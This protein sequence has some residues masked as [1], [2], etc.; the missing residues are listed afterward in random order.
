MKKILNENK[1][2][3]WLLYM[4]I[5]TLA[6]NLAEKSI[7]DNYWVS[8]LPLDDKI[9]FVRQ[10]VYPYVFWYIFMCGT[11]LYLLIKDPDGFR[12]YMI[13]I[14]IGYSCT[15]VFCFIFPNG[16]NLRVQQPG[17]DFAGSLI[18]SIYNRDTNTNVL[19]S[20]HVLGTLDVVFAVF[21]CKSL[22]N[23]ILRV[24]TVIIGISICASTVMIKQHS[25]LDVITALI[26]SG[27]IYLL[28]YVFMSRK[29]YP[30]FSK[31]KVIAFVEGLFFRD[32]TVE[33]APVL[34]KPAPGRQGG[35]D[36]AGRAF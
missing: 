7:V 17:E 18:Q 11:G 24:C 5:Y 27:I 12:R 2:C 30:D 3:I 35:A 10:M 15:L 21:Y 23:P 16:Q 32:K 6:F 26:L 8:Y 28:V 19:P 1:H 14:A 34:L 13:T 31:A 20:M 36:S 33:R 4:V 25:I 22:K 29:K 9:P